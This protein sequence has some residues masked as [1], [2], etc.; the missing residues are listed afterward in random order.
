MS[1]LKVETVVIDDILVHPNAEKLEFA[2]VKG[3]QCIVQKGFFQKGD[4]V[5]YIPI[6]SILPEELEK[7][8]FGPDSKI[9]L[10]K[11]RVKTIK[12]RGA[13]SQG[14]IINL[15]M[16]GIASADEPVAG[17]DIT[18]KLGITKYEPDIPD[19]QKNMF[20]GRLASKKEVN[21]H[22]HKYT[23]IANI[24]NF[25]LLFEPDEVVVATEKIHGTNFR[26]GYVPF[27]PVTIW[28]RVKKFFG[29]APEFQFVFGSHNVQLQHKMLYDG[30]FDSNVYASA[31]KKWKLDKILKNGEVVY[32]E[33]YGDGIQKNYNYGLKDGEKSL[34]VFDIMQDNAYLNRIDFLT[35]T[36]QLGLKTPPELYF[37]AYKDLSI[38]KIVDGDSIFVPDQKVREGAVIKPIIENRSYHGGGRKILKAINP[39]YLL[40]DNSDFH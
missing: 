17:I 31:V 37:G 35:R 6:D 4:I 34:V 16:A 1:E 23:D 8:I 19:F 14:L 7:K 9:V 18:E 11:H 29:F 2:V 15:G 33:I 20:K 22:F 10:H 12:I 28:E 32:G 21:P 3:W 27:V 39:Q 5:V 30:F 13:I 38:A 40:K 36:S 26:A 24:K 25:V